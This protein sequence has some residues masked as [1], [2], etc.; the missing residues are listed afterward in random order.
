MVAR[1]LIAKLVTCLA[2]LLGIVTFAHAED[3]T[4]NAVRPWTIMI[5]MNGKNNLEPDA[6]NNFYA[7]ASIGSTEQVAI[8]TQFGRPRNPTAAEGGWSGVN[9]FYIKKDLR[10]RKEN[11]IEKLPEGAASDMGRRE[12]LTDFIAW[13]KAKYPAEHYMLIVWNHGQ[14][15]RL[16]MAALASRVPP[17]NKPT[18]RNASAV[19]GFRAVSSDDD[20]G[21]ILYNS[22]VEQAIASN[23]QGEQKL[24]ILGFDACLMAMIETAYAVAP[25]TRLMVASEELE[26]GD[27]WQY[28]KWLDKVVANPQMSGVDVGKAVVSSYADH[29]GN[30][31]F[32]TLSLLD[33]SYV[34]AAAIALTE[35]AD[36]IRKSGPKAIDAMRK[37]RADVSSYA[38]WDAPP[39]RLSVDLITLLE[40]F[41]ARTKN[42]DLEN[43]AANA[44]EKIRPMVVSNYASSRSQ[45]ELGND[46]YG[47]Q[48]VAIYYPKTARDFRQDYFHKGYLKENKDRPIAFVKDE[49][50]AELLYVL[51]GI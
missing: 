43:I 38:D 26:P 24:D 34:E 12:T 36:A 47:S 7:M 18:E 13:S 14:G 23:F 1:G 16:Q 27:G 37:A 31:Y 45:G 21:S 6:L 22:E 3:V 32:T 48:G 8:V 20:T 44:I 2:L 41:R 15:Y 19:G 4:G 17:V 28:A 51:L 5:Y 29:Y 33:I 42:S 9:R 30:S 35:F 39:S 11:A 10:P 25:S 50:W 40:R 49:R 46:L